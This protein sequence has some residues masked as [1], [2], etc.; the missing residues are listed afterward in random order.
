M[1]K[2]GVRGGLNYMGLFTWDKLGYLAISSCYT[3]VGEKGKK[4]IKKKNNKKNK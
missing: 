1:Y 4:K 2:S 3:V